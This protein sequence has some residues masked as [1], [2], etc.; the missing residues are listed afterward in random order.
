MGSPKG[1]PITLITF[2]NFK[3]FILTPYTLSISSLCYLKPHRSAI[4]EDPSRFSLYIFIQVIQFVRSYLTR[5]KK[6][7][8][9]WT[10]YQISYLSACTIE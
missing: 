4:A 3:S 10:I 2:S 1:A 8:K 6:G 7:V 5:T 9:A